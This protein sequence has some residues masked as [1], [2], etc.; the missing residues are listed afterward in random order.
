L[1]RLASVREGRQ[2]THFEEATMATATPAALRRGA[3]GDKVRRLQS[4]LTAAG[5][6]CATDGDFGPATERAV[7]AFQAAKGLTADGIAGPMTR[8]ALKAK[9]ETAAEEPKRPKKEKEKGKKGSLTE[10]GATF[11]GH[12]EGFSDCLYNDPVGHCTIGYGHL[13]HRGPI[14]GSEPAEF[15]RKITRERGLE[16]L[17]ED[18][19]EAATAVRKHVSVDLKPHQRDALISFTYN[20]GGGAFASSTLVKMLNTG[21][22]GAVPKQLM[23]WTLADGKRLP[24]LVRRRE[25]EGRLFSRGDYSA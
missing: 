24:G 25:A 18:A 11:I 16:L 10:R 8:A 15:K 1:T 22:Y 21:D 3:Q 14:N 17:R 9:A 13:V 19:E 5:F 20:V 6:Q 23:R 7:K 12:F 4:A 2:R